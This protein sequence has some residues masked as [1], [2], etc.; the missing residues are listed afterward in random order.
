MGNGEDSLDHTLTPLLVPT[1]LAL[2]FMRRLQQVDT[3]LGTNLNHSK[4]ETT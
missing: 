1:V 4:R 2:Q 3:Y